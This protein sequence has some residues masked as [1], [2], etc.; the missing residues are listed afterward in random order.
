LINQGRIML[1]ISLSKGSKSLS[2]L[3]GIT[4]ASAEQ[5]FSQDG[6]DQG[7][8]QQ[9]QLAIQETCKSIVNGKITAIAY[10]TALFA[11]ARRH[12]DLA[13]FAAQLEAS[14]VA[15]AKKIDD[16]LHAGKAPTAA[17]AGHRT[18]H[19]FSGPGD[20]AA[21][22]GIVPEARPCKL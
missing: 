17:S 15:T 2:D 8:D 6:E 21:L 18:V 20:G 4:P 13:P 3:L 22:P 14:A 7:A 11:H 1:K 9:L 19:P 10:V 12:P 5:G 16:A